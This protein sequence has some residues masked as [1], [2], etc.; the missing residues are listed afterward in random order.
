[1]RGKMCKRF[2]VIALA[3]MLCFESTVPALASQNASLMTQ[4][5]V[6]ENVMPEGM[7]PFDIS[8]EA[9][10]AAEVS[11]EEFMTQ[12][13][14]EESDLA[15]SESEMAEAFGI[16]QPV[17][18]EV[19]ANTIS[20]NSAEV[21]A[22]KATTYATLEDAADYVRGRM[23]ARKELTTIRV[24]GNKDTA[25]KS[26]T[27]ILDKVFEYD[28]NG[29]P[30]EGDY[31]YW[32]MK[33][34][35]WT[36]PSK[37]SD[38]TYTI[39]LG[40]RYRTSAEEEKYVTKR[41]NAIVSNLNL[42]S[43]S[44]NDYQKV[45]AIYDYIM[46]IVE[47]DYYHY[48]TDQSYNY[49][50][51]TYEA[52]NSGFAVCQ[53]YAT[54]FYRLCEEAGISARV[55]CGNDDSSGSPTHGW[56]IVKLG[57]YYYN[58]DATWDDSDTPTH[59]YFLKNME[60][61]V[62]HQRNAVNDGTA[63]DKAFPTAPVSYPTPEADVTGKIIDVANVTGSLALVNGESYS[64]AAGSGKPKVVFFINPT[65]DG[66]LTWTEQFFAIESL[67][68][69]AYDT[70][71]VDI[72]DVYEKYEDYEN[73]PGQIMEAIMALTDA[74]Y[75]YNFSSDYT[76]GLAY[77][78]QYASAVGMPAG[79]YCS[80]AV[81]DG[82]NRLRYF[83][84]ADAAMPQM[85]K[86]LTEI[87][88]SGA[89]G[90]VAGINAVQTQNN[91]VKVTW[92]AYGGATGYRVYRKMNSGSYYCV[93]TTTGTSFTD[94]IT[95][96]YTY[97]YQVRAL[98]GSKEIASSA[99]KSIVTKVMLL[100][101]GKTYTVGGY[102]YKVLKSSNSTK[103]VAFAGV[104]NKKLTKI[105]IPDT[106]VINGMKYKVTEIANNALKNNKKVK[107]VSIGANVTKIGKQAFFKATKLANIVVKT[108]KLKSV[109]K[110]ALYGISKKAE[111]RVPS[112]KLAK[113]KKLF[114]G[115]GQKSSV[116]IKK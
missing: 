4:A 100:K 104:S 99:Q 30:S 18:E 13:G 112:S 86:I 17:T 50:Y 61:F 19:S 44:L 80:V 57:A 76:K 65:E 96:K 98:Y 9:V 11:E 39:R 115:K 10:A 66:S 27:K 52:L 113:Y 23:V 60:D 83:D 78:N 108:K 58:V 2:L 6:S 68:T 46:S 28:I 93:G 63:F 72:C 82:D 53:A 14:L 88:Y 5:G 8:E 33:Y 85:E 56:N 102:K 81:I 77:R 20:A 21:S 62:G 26:V 7:Q 64:L 25:L 45:R 71:I 47:Y 106:V 29:E 110:K 43:P 91:A 79:C 16:K 35:Q 95:P 111:I 97:T 31:L 75:A 1:M 70:L 51:T 94:E 55:I 73:M 105:L 109:G 103:T 40:F 92:N 114:K 3:F 42:K 15:A 48:E 67:G 89:Y 84:Y 22:D 34:M 41:V 49:M 59:I 54:L 24:A 12:F 116:K 101:K 69:R 90:T 107:T 37:N 74:P 87:T 32:H 36:N 38:G